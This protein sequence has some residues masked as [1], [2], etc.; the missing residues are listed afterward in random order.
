[1][2][3]YVCVSIRHQKKKNVPPTTHTDTQ[4]LVKS[5]LAVEDCQPERSV[6]PAANSDKS[7]PWCS[8]YVK[9][10]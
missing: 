4:D 9:A 10:L 3:V 5:A 7:V 1:V 6:A 2:C 8:Y